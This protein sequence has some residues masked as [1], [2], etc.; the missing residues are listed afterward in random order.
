MMAVHLGK[1][2]A[3]FTADAVNVHH[4]VRQKPFCSPKVLL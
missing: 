1:V 4:F 2:F 3:R